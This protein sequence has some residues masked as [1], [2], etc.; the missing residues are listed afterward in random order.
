MVTRR[1]VSLMLLLLLGLGAAL[2]LSGVLA[3]EPANTKGFRKAVTLEGIRAHQAAFQA[4]ADQNGGTRASGTSGYDASAQY[5]FERL[6]AAGYS[7]RFQ[8]FSFPFVVRSGSARELSP[9]AREIQT[10]TMTFSPSTPAAGITAALAVVPVDADPG[11][12]AADFAGGV[13]TGKIALVKRGAC[14]FSIKAANAADAGAIAV[15]VYDNVDGPLITPTLGSREAAR[16]PTAFISLA[17]GQTLTADTAGG[18]QIVTVN[19]VTAYREETR[20]TVNVIAETAGDINRTVVVGAHLDSVPAG[21]G[22]N[23]NGSGSATILEIAETFAVQQ[24]EARNKLR[25]IWYGAEELGLLGARYY[26]GQLSQAER[27]QIEL[28]LNF[29]MVGSPNYVR[30]VYDGNNSAFPVGP[31][32]AAGPAGSGAIEEVFHS[33]FASEGLASAETPF[34]GRSDYGPFIEVGI[35]AGGLFTGAEGVKTATQAA[36][37]GGTAG[38]AYDP[39]YHAACDTFANFSAD[40]LDQMSDAAAHAVLLFSKWNFDQTALVDGPPTKGQGNGGE[41]GGLHDDHDHDEQVSQ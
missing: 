33:Y 21:P 31:G 9:V 15:L 36:I 12:Q 38:R 30:F 28:N 16:V 29:D 27:D 39:C 26:V 35:P 23:D 17:S 24:R 5:V 18:T 34:S 11:C 22:I 14:N 40:G 2:P 32:A 3:D 1:F 7:P 10:S 25:F 20:Q 13:Y 8:T 37:Y 41:G 19:L 4:I 6:Q